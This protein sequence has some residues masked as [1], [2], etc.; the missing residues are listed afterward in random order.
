[1]ANTAGY[2]GTPLIKKLGIKPGTKLLLLNAPGNYNELLQEDITPQLCKG[3]QIPD[4]IH[5]FATHSLV[6]EKG[7]KK[8]LNTVPK[9]TNITVWVSWYKKSS[10]IKTDLTED[11]IRDFA[12]ANGLVDV[13]VCAVDNVWSGLKLV[14]PL[15]KR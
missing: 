12:L 14:V 9:N 8:V 1:M 11:I 13:K 7:M 3:N 5:L 2:S 6:F 10:G 4:F 15:A